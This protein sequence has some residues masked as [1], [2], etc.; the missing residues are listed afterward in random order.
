MAGITLTYYR[1]EAGQMPADVK[2]KIAAAIKA[3]PESAKVAVC[4]TE[5]PPY[6]EP[7][8]AQ[9]IIESIVTWFAGLPDDCNDLHGLQ[10]A[11]RL[12]ACYKANFAVTVGM[13]KKQYVGAEFRRKAFFATQKRG[14]MKSGEAKSIAAAETEVEASEAYQALRETEANAEGDLFAANLILNNSADVL[15]TM[16]QLVSTLKMQLSDEMKGRGSQAT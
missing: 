6:G 14:L 1:D 9:G 15:Q 12:L 5:A 13:L 7:D 3:V 8:D 2:A 10:N 11:A 4:V 16:Q